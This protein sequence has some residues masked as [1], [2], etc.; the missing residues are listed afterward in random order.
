MGLHKDGL[1][2]GNLLRAGTWALP[3]GLICIAVLLQL[4]G[5]PVRH[6]LAWSRVDIGAGEAWRL[7][8]G[9]VVHLGWSHLVLNAAGLAL[10]W[11]LVGDTFDPAGWLVVGI[12]SIAAIDLGFWLLSP[13]LYWY[14]GL[15][16][17]LHG[18]LVAGIA[19]GLARHS[20]ESQ[21]LALL[22]AAKLVW[23][24]VSGPLPG[25]EETSGGAVIVDAH[26]YGSLGGLAGAW[27]ARRRVRPDSPI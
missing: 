24:Q 2:S 4:G 13:E 25:S 9:H 18:L 21:V 1:F 14:V 6:W 3:A 27:L 17:I 8:S 19:I 7:L 11:V 20:R 5:D 22:I 23:E 15:S 12:S 16:G 10:I 26:L